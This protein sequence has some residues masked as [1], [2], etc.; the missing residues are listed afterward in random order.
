MI[1]LSTLLIGV[2][3]RGSIHAD[4]VNAWQDLHTNEGIPLPRYMRGH[5]TAV[6]ARNRLRLIA[7]ASP[8]TQFLLMVDDDVIPDRSLLTMIDP[9][10][11]L[12]GAPVMIQHAD[13]NVPF[14]NVYHRHPT[15]DGWMPDPGMFEKIGTGPAVVDAIGFGAVAIRRDILAGFPP[16]WLTIDESG[17]ASRS[18][19][20]VY[21]QLLTDAGIDVWCDWN[22]RA[23]HQPLVNLQVLQERNARAFATYQR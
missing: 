15:A 4:I 16:F 20:L 19:D 22:A 14:F 17:V 23:L 9:T 10:Y 11:P 12:V 21:C 7:L 5:L 13:A 8:A 6:D 2:P 3:T 18:E 1:D